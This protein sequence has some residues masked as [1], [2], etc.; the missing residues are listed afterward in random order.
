MHF[1]PKMVDTRRCFSLDGDLLGVRQGKI[2]HVIPITDEGEQFCAAAAQGE[3]AYIGYAIGKIMDE[4][5]ELRFAYRCPAAG[6][7]AAERLCGLL[8]RLTNERLES[9]LLLLQN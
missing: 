6:D 9:D 3:V 7:I 8:S 4:E 1:E 2:M 5:G